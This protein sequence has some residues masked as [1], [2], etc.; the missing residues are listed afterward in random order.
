MGEIRRTEQQ[1]IRTRASEIYAKLLGIP[2]GDPRRRLL[3]SE[4]HLLREK[5]DEL[6]PDVVDERWLSRRRS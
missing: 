2:Y 3:E 4:L 5:H 1:A 6:E